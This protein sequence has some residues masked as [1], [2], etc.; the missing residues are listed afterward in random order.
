MNIRYSN[1]REDRKKWGHNSE[2]THTILKNLIQQPNP[3]LHQIRN[4]M[5]NQ[6]EIEIPDEIFEV[7]RQKGPNVFRAMEEGRMISLRKLLGIIEDAPLGTTPAN[8]AFAL[9]MLLNNDIN[10]I[11]NQSLVDVISAYPTVVNEI[12]TIQVEDLTNSF[13]G[14]SSFFEAFN[15]SERRI[16]Q[17]P[18]NTLLHQL[19]IEKELDQIKAY[20]SAIYQAKQAGAPIPFD[21]E[22][23]NQENKTILQLAFESG[24]KDIISAVLVYANPNRTAYETQILNLGINIPEIIR[25]QH[26]LLLETTSAIN[27]RQQAISNVVQHTNHNVGVLAIQQANTDANVQQVAQITALNYAAVRTI[28]HHVGLQLPSMRPTV[29]V[30]ELTDD[31]QVRQ[32]PPPAARLLIANQPAAGENP[33]RLFAITSPSNR[34]QNTNS[35]AIQEDPLVLIRAIRAEMNT[36]RSEIQERSNRLNELDQRV[37]QIESAL[38]INNRITL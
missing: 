2:G 16:N 5:I 1:N 26:N 35:A 38:T 25:Q 33:N 29:T 6:T 36:L 12:F 32:L 23:K 37:S 8:P 18:G 34:P 11:S 9:Q 14:I 21:P 27:R 3:D 17:P 10:F 7:A 24:N 22:K 20:M 19:I 13:A 30:T 31:P 15:R 4:F 28:G